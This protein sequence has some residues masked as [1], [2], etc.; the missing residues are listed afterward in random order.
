MALKKI[1]K[2]GK[3]QLNKKLEQN[4]ISFSMRNKQKQKPREFKRIMQNC[5]DLKVKEMGNFLVK[6]MYQKK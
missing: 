2:L 3:I 5:D 6:I 4:F 1:S